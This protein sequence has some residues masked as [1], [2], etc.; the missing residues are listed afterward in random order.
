MKNIKNER[1]SLI[2]E[3]DQ[4]V[5]ADV[6][7]YSMVMILISIFVFFTVI[8]NGSF[9]APNNIKDLIN[10]TGY[11]AVLAVGMTLVIIVKQ[12]DLSVGYM[13]GLFGAVSA[14]LIMKHNVPTY[15]VIPLVL[16]LGAFAGFISGTIISRAGVSSFVMT[17]AGMFIYRGILLK[18]TNSTGTI[19]IQNDAF[20]AI[21]NGFLPNLSKGSFNVTAILVGVVSIVLVIYFE[22]T[23]RKKLKSYGLKIRSTPISIMKIVWI[24]TLIIAF[25]WNQ[26]YANGISY[27]AVIVASVVLLYSYIMKNTTIGR[28]IYGVG[29]NQ[30]AALLSGINVPLVITLVFVSMGILCALSG[31]M[32]A[33]R[34]Q[35]VTPTAGAGIEIY[36]I[37]AAYLGGVSNKGGVGKIGNSVMGA[38]IITSLSSGMNI[39]GL[40]VYVQYILIGIVLISIVAFDVKV[41]KNRY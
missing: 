33:S 29:N 24:A 32:Y 39:L 10:Q 2:N 8:T 15:L 35:S 17:L 27:T 25:V 28:H 40:Q 11:I 23:N 16:I 37:G 1:L 9:V 41:H 30:D 13:S 20:Y 36:A 26:A 22:I 21:S 18:L 31:M 5:K 4:I 6:F 3:I 19:A 34:I 38:L 7:D 12:I 14:I